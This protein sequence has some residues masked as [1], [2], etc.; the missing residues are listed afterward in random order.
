MTITD[1]IFVAGTKQEILG[2][3]TCYLDALQRADN[4]N[5][6]PEALSRL[7]LASTHD[8]HQR[9]RPLLAGLDAASKNLDDCAC[10]IIK[11]GL[12]IFLAASH[13]LDSLEAGTQ[14]AVPVRKQPLPLPW[15]TPPRNSP[16]PGNSSP[17][18]SQETP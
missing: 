2:L 5:N 13:R 7:P 10:L 6:L 17:Q 18:R 12:A 8:V 9:I 3:L 1:A 14:T 15:T 16:L 11:E 4:S